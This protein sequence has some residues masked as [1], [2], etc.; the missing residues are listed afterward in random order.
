MASWIATFIIRDGKKTFSEAKPSGMYFLNV[1]MTVQP[2]NLVICCQHKVAYTLYFVNLNRYKLRH[3]QFKGEGQEVITSL[4]VYVCHWVH[5]SRMEG[6]G[7]Q[8]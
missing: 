5:N 3:Q 2:S 8:I 7:I 6:H 1:R 4:A